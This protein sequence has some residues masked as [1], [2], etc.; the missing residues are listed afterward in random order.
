A[1]RALVGDEIIQ[2]A[3]AQP[4]GGGLWRL[5]TLLRGRGGTEWAVGG[6]TIGDRFVLLD[7]ALTPIDPARVTQAANTA[8]VAVGL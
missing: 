4:L 6:H 2:F 7:A 8:V 5:G 3:S 1:N